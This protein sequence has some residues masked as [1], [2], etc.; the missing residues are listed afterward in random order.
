[1]E[2]KLKKREEI[3]EYMEK[4]MSSRENDMMSSKDE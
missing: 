1:M 3:G 4:I 2:R